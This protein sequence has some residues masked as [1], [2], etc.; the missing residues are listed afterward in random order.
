MP[1]W[2]IRK[3]VS[4]S[5]NTSHH[6]VLAPRLCEISRYRTNSPAVGYERIEQHIRLSSGGS[7]TS[8]PSL[9]IFSPPRNRGRRE[10]SGERAG[11]VAGTLRRPRR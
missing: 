9:D 5:G 11:P 1:R 3:A 10:F 6:R 7:A 4:N 2:E 8:V